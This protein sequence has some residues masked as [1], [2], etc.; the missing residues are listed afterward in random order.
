METHSPS[1]QAKTKEERLG[2]EGGEG[3]EGE[4]ERT[5]EVAVGSVEILMS[6]VVRSEED[7]E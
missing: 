3:G 7:W 4:T 6:T 1:E 5:P 2:D